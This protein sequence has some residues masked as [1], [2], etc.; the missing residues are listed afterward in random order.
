MKETKA[1]LVTRVGVSSSADPMLDRFFLDAE[2]L[3]LPR[4]LFVPIA[5]SL[6]AA[7]SHK[8]LAGCGEKLTKNVI[9]H[10]NKRQLSLLY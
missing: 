3:E 9:V 10:Y 8:S 7:T 4:R 6:C 5:A 1:T 2:P